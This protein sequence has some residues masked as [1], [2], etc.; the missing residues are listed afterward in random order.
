MD[1]LHPG[2]EQEVIACFFAVK[3]MREIGHSKVCEQLKWEMKGISELL[4]YLDY[5]FLQSYFNT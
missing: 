2:V 3:G 5:L 1:F 4:S